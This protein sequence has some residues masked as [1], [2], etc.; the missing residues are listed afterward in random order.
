MLL[1]S[2]EQIRKKRNRLDD[3]IIDYSKVCSKFEF[4]EERSDGRSELYQNIPNSRLEKGREEISS[5]LDILAFFFSR[6][7]GGED[8]CSISVPDPG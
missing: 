6:C 4:K 5:I 1:S 8:G 7:G 2:F 3:I